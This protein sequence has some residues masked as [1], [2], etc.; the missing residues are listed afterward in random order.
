MNKDIKPLN[1][2]GQRHGLWEWYYSNGNLA[3]KCFYH[4]GKRVG[5]EE[6]Y[7]YNNGKL[8]KKIYYI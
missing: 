8:I 5:Y 4:N 6:L 1:D 7:S 3:Y 2:K